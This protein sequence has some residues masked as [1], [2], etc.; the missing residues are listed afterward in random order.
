MGSVAACR[1]WWYLTKTTRESVV[2]GIVWV[3]IGVIGLVSFLFFGGSSLPFLPTLSLILWIFWLVWG[4][5]HLISA[6][7]RHRREHAGR[8]P[9]R[10]A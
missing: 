10:Q 1:P 6:A 8:N 7:V 3:A 4:V 2:T 5:A 9:A